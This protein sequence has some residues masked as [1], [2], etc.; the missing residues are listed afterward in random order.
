MRGLNFYMMPVLEVDIEKKERSIIQQ[1]WLKTVP[2][3]NKTWVL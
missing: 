1:K 3:F 2:K